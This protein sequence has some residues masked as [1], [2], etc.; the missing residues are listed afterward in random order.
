MSDREITNILYEE[1]YQAF[2]DGESISNVARMINRKRQTV[3]E[4]FLRRGYSLTSRKK[5]EGALC[6]SCFEDRLKLFKD[7]TMNHTYVCTNTTCK[8]RI[9][10]SKLETWSITPSTLG[11]QDN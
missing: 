2:L 9:D 1:A 6:V 11:H 8:M 10:V 5:K 7:N 4:A 3:I